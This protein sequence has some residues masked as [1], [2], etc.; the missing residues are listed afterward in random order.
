MGYKAFLVGVNTHGLQYSERDTELMNVCLTKHGYKIIES[1][2]K[3]KRSILEQFEEMLKKCDKTDTIIFYFSGHASLLKGKLRLVLDDTN[4]PIRISEI[5]EPLEECRATNKLIILDCCHAGAATADLQL[6][7]S[8]AYSI[9]TASTR[10]E[11]SKEIDDFNAGFLTYQ[12]NQLLTYNI[13]EICVDKKITIHRFYDSLNTAAKQYNLNHS[14]QVPIPNLFYN[15][16]N[17]FE[18][19]ACE[20]G[21]GNGESPR[22]LARRLLKDLLP[23]QFR[24][25]LF[26]YEIPDEYLSTAAPQ[27]TQISELIKYALQ[28]E[29]EPLTKLLEVIT[30]VH[31][32]A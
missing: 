15:A 5:T 20:S 8:D 22:L 7:L 32:K 23:A 29:G 27:M 6:D 21:N 14:V 24:D 3:E 10:M 17:N 26:I 25:V 11:K 1:Y 28:Q 31:G 4:N 16:R 9:L 19:A 12:I 18:I 13:A 30:Q 2:R